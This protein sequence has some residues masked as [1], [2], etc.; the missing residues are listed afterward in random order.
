MTKN[1]L[2]LMVFD[3]DR[4]PRKEAIAIMNNKNFNNLIFVSIIV[5]CLL[6]AALYDPLDETKN[7]ALSDGTDVFFTF[8]FMFEMFVKIVALGLLFGEEAYLRNGWNILDGIVVI[9]SFVCLDFVSGGAEGL[10]SLRA[11]RAVRPLR[12]LSRFKSG[13]LF[14]NTLFSS[15]Q[16]IMNVFIFLVWFIILGACAGTVLF[17]GELRSRCFD[18]SANADPNTCPSPDEL[19][20]GSIASPAR[21]AVL[22]DTG[23]DVICGVALDNCPAA[24]HTCC[25]Y[26]KHG[27]MPSGGYV[28]FDNVLWSS[29][30]VLQGLTIDGWNE[31]AY[32]LMDAIGWPVLLWY[33]L[34]V[35]V[36]AFFVMQ[37]LSA[38]VVTSLQTCS[39]EQKMVDQIDAE[40]EKRRIEAGGNPD[41]KE[42]DAIDEI[43]KTW[44]TSKSLEGVRKMV[45][46]HMRRCTR[47]PR[48]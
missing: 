7:A 26:A 29:L 13:A 12:T 36:G 1:P 46:L 33:A 42:G 6:M 24:S 43:G 48:A 38:V 44:R 14:V 2:S 39:A 30:L 8:L 10:N 41:D 37:L 23:D 17:R 27:T 28:K 11:I 18:I 19:Y 9:I 35:C 15:A 25:D 4:S 40:R 20:A 45:R 32:T 16:Y 22:T 47:S 21:Y 31:T 5:N 34:M 3:R